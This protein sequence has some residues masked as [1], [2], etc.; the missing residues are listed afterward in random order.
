MR[1]LCG[2]GEGED[3]GGGYDQVWEDI[4]KNSRGPGE[5]IE[6]SS[7]GG[8]GGELGKPLEIP[9]LQ[10]C[11]RFPGPNGEEISQNTQ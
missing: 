7:S 2:R 3:K 11:E 1:Y 4:G 5:Q 6:I 10:E 8:T 9:R